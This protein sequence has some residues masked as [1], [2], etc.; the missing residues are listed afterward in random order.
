ML[1]LTTIPVFGFLL[2]LPFLLMSQNA[3]LVDSL[4]TELR[5]AKN[6]DQI[7]EI[8]IQ[9]YKQLQRSD[10]ESSRYY[11]NNAITALPRIDSDSI[12]ALVYKSQA[13]DHALR[14]QYDSVFKYANKAAKLKIF[15]SPRELIDL[16]SI[17][18]TVF[19]YKGEYAKAI[20]WHMKAEKVAENHDYEV[21]KARVYN[22]IAI[23]YLKIEDWNNA[24]DFLKQ[25]A[26]YL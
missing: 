25:I 14:H 1:K 6:P 16:Y 10:L 20:S 3:P 21:G 19:Y 17:K 8:N 18:G 11:L 13:E 24:E 5:T 9:L 15:L 23:A 12:R 7:I 22:N 26:D 2:L 4:K